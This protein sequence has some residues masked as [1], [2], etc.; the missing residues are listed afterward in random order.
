MSARVIR[1]ILLFAVASLL[2]NARCIDDCSAIVSAPLKAPVTNCPLHKSTG[3]RP[4]DCERQ[5][6]QFATAA[7]EKIQMDRQPLV[8]ASL[9]FAPPQPLQIAARRTPLFRRN[10]TPPAPNQL[11]RV[12]VLR[13]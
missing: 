12:T 13:V 10:E 5:H 6:P 4:A 2:G 1:A 8:A 7:T 9:D 3:G 11:V